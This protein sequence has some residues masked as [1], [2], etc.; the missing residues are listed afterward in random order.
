MS[1]LKN[2]SLKIKIIMRNIF[3]QTITISFII[4]IIGF[5]TKAKAGNIKEPWQASPKRQLLGNVATIDLTPDLKM[6]FA[7]GGYGSRMSKPAEAVHDRIWAKALVI[8]EGDKKYAIVTLDV[9]GLPPNVKPSLVKTLSSYGWKMENI[10]LLPSHSHTSFDMPA[11]NNLNH[12]NSPQI[13]IFQPELLEY[14]INA[15]S[16][17]IREADKNLQ[18]V[19]VGSSSVL[20]NNMNRNRR[21][22][23]DV[24]NEITLTRID[25]TDGTPMTALVNWTAHPTFMSGSDMSVSGGWPG[26]L[27][28]ELEQW[29]GGGITVMYYNGAEGDQS[30]IGKSAGS[31][32]E[33]AEIYGRDLAI[34]VQELY[35]NTKTSPNIVFEYNYNTLDLPTRK[36][37]PSFMETGGEEYN[38]TPEALDAVLKVMCPEKTYIGAVRIG[39][40]LIVGAPGELAAGLGLNVKNILKEKGI[41]HPVIG[42]LANEWIS[43]ILSADQYNHGAGYESSVSFYGDGLGKVIVDRML[44]T[45]IPLTE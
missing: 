33:K 27:Q 38:L 43:Y 36:V 19:K 9:L 30:P 13:G 35:K 20:L 7:L 40:L 28:R 21:G 15:L 26:Y 10:M 29:I 6:K 44:D 3:T 2:I 34:K 16:K 8:K 5:S 1:S 23:P 11:L 42:G 41:K 32:Y 17:L 18:P 39:E 25:Y 22:D 45:S 24:D 12:L 14:V 31:H 4:L 37:H